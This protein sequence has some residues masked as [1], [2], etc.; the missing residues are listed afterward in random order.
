[1]QRQFRVDRVKRVEL[2]ALIRGRKRFDVARGDG[3]LELG[4]QR[5]A[6]AID[7]RDVDGRKARIGC[8]QA[9]R[10]RL[11]ARVDHVREGAKAVGP[12]VQVPGHRIERA[13][14]LQA[15][16]ELVAREQVIEVA[17]FRRI[18]Q[19][20]ELAE[21]AFAAVAAGLQG[22]VEQVTVL[23]RADRFADARSLRVV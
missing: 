6:P 7:G 20:R 13:V 14:V 10:E 19:L 11:L 15:F 1:M 16:L 12:R 2:L 4:L 17:R 3:R 5:I 23:D 8:G 21:P 18:R 22:G 9:L